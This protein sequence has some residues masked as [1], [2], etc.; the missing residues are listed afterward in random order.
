MEIVFLVHVAA[1][2]AMAG[3]IWFVQIVHYPLFSSVGPAQFVGYE[4]R[5]TRRTGW[6]VGVLMPAEA[7]TGLWLAIDPPGQVG[8][9]IL[10]IGLALIA[11]LWI[12]TLLW[13]V[14][15]H[16]RL[17]AGYQPG[18]V[19]RLVRSNWVRTAIWSV[20]GILVLAV[21]ADLLD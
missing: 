9:L 10:L 20:R 5:H 16:R 15:L 7:G 21:A 1:T 3:L 12:T 8:N 13:Q 14:P 19:S 4:A 2:L 6:V 18:L 11:L 17:T